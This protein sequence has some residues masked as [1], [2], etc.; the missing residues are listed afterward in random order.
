ML[1]KQG[2]SEPLN[3]GEQ[4]SQNFW[5]KKQ[6]FRGEKVVQEDSLS[7]ERD[8]SPFERQLKGLREKLLKA[9]KNLRQQIFPEDHED[10]QPAFWVVVGGQT[11]FS[12]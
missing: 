12:S 5:N 10:I 4:I 11:H 2:K 8:S 3:S 1:R 6:S 7:L 9:P